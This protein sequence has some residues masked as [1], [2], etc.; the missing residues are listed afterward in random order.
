M[1]TSAVAATWTPNSVWPPDLSSHPAPATTDARGEER[2]VAEIRPG[3]PMDW[4]PVASDGPLF[5]AS[6]RYLGAVE[7]QGELPLAG[8]AQGEG[9]GS[10]TATRLR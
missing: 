3:S 8:E 9:A 4:A 7:E 6:H 1:A 5:L 10:S 2:V